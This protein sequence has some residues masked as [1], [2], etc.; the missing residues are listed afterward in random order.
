MHTETIHF[1]TPV[2]R[3][4]IA[5]LY[6]R[7]IAAET[8]KNERSFSYGS[9]G[10]GFCD[11]G[12][13]PP[14]DEMKIKLANISGAVHYCT[15]ES[16][17]GFLGTGETTFI[18]IRNN[19]LDSEIKILGTEDRVRH[20]RS[21][22]TD[23]MGVEGKCTYRHD[24]KREHN[25][26]IEA[27]FSGYVPA[28]HWPGRVQAIDKL[29]EELTGVRLLKDYI[30]NFSQDWPRMIML[31]A[32]YVGLKFADGELRVK[33]NATYYEPSEAMGTGSFG[34]GAEFV[35]RGTEESVE[36]AFRTS[37]QRIGFPRDVEPPLAGRIPFRQDKGF[38]NRFFS[39]TTNAKGWRAAVKAVAAEGAELGKYN[40]SLC[41][42]PYNLLLRESNGKISKDGQVLDPNWGE[43]PLESALAHGQISSVVNL[44]NGCSPE[45]IKK[46]FP[47]DK[48]DE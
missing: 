5:D 19:K 6:A 2:N 9:N 25:A 15:M 33:V 41:R 1:N 30:P 42:F 26:R 21:V 28:G 10:S 7:T 12:C 27:R 4:Q 3:E 18:D 48:D 23:L 37:I 35:Y 8:R 38:I 14:A 20:V 29:T 46:I 11:A 22:L 13:A 39:D 16:S 31:D 44:D 32:N 34:V 17:L 40:Y 43:D 24:Y 36:R 47:K 45:D